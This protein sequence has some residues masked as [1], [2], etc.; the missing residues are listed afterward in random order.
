ML[1]IPI[2]AGKVSDGYHTFDELYEHR[3]LLFINLVHFNLGNAAWKPHFPDWDCYSSRP[4]TVKSVTTFPRN[5][6]RCTRRA[7]N[8]TTTISGMVTR[9]RTL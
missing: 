8:A 2:D 1:H 3:C 5:T 9:Q 7:S 6:A 4:S